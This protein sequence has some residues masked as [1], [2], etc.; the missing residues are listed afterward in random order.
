MN[1]KTLRLEKGLSQEKLAELSCL[2]LRTIQRIEKE[3]K[4]SI[5]SL[6]ALCTVFHKEIN[7]MKLIVEQSS[8]T[9]DTIKKY[10]HF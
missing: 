1:L 10:N 3:Q 8:K 2:S 9:Q 7:E 4:A 6:N 5:E